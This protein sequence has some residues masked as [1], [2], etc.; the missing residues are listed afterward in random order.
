MKPGA[1]LGFQRLL[2]VLLLLVS[3]LSGRLFKATLRTVR[4]GAPST[5][6]ILDN[7]KPSLIFSGDDHECVDFSS[8][9]LTATAIDPAVNPTSLF[10]P[11]TQHLRV[12]PTR[13][14]SRGHA[15]VLLASHGRFSPRSPDPFAHRT[16]SR[17]PD[18]NYACRHALPSS[19]SGWNLLQLLFSARVRY[20]SCQNRLTPCCCLICLLTDVHVRHTAFSPSSSFSAFTPVASS[21]AIGRLLLPAHPPH[22]L[23]QLTSTYLQ[24]PTPLTTV[25]CPP[26][27]T[28][29]PPPLT[30]LAC[31]DLLSSTPPTPTLPSAE[32]TEA[33][34][35]AHRTAPE[36]RSYQISRA[37]REEEEP[38]A[39]TETLAAATFL[40]SSP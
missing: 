38:L 22:S 37:A 13:I 9:V 8:P 12:Q 21:P 35:P 32:T 6:F 14:R 1:G 27:A 23:V 10:L 15:Q 24:T 3:T 4:R 34:L 5:K 33:S 26:Q 40:L 20:L 11:S 16:R 28:T 2:Y 31:L 19:E 17:E 39:G 18:N 30:P 29:P 36:A 7:V 25:E